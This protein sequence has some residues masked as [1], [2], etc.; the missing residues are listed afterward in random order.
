MK[1]KGNLSPLI[2]NKRNFEQAWYGFS[3]G[4]GRRDSIRKFEE[5]L[6]E[7]L[8][9]LLEAYANGTWRTS[10]YRNEEIQERKKRIISKYPIEE[11][12]IQWAAGIF[13]EPLLCDTFIRR[14]CSCVAGRGT[15]DFVDLLRKDMSLHYEDTYY[16]VQL[17]AH[18]YFQHIRSDLMKASLRRKIKDAKLLRFLDEFI[19]SY[20][21][22]LPLGLKISQILANY[23]LAAFDRDVIRIFGIADDPDKMAYWRARYV[24]DCFVTCRTRQQADELAKGV[25]YLN[26]KFDGYVKEGM[27]HY[28]RFADNIIIQHRDKAF[29]HLVTEMAIMV[30]AR[31]YYIDVNKE[32]NVRPVHAGGIDVCGYVSFHDH[33]LLRKRNKVNLCK[34][35]AKYRKRGLSPEEIRRKC[36]SRIGFATH[37]NSNNLLRKLDINMEK[38]LGTVIKNKKYNIPFKGMRFDQKKPFSDLICKTEQ[39]EDSHKIM[40]MDY[41]V[42]DSKVEKES[43]IMEVPDTASGGTKMERVERPKKCLVIRYKRIVRTIVSPTIDGG[44]DETYIFE[45]ETDKNGNPTSKDAEY[46]SY[47]GST[48]LLEQAEN[49]FDKEDLPCITV[50]MEFTNKLNKKFYKFT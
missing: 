3:D 17:D 38:R 8:D 35:V 10:D 37:A 34:E 29:L 11:H 7:N 32:W 21:Q 33:R 49:D 13:V 16:F 39:D 5:H 41:T 40:L 28:S 24:T 1:R 46:Y 6:S 15:H 31:D 26:A 2:E 9:R 36:A 47:T 18:H 50:I 43:V 25:A 14:S 44:E 30:L 27:R 22:G 42:E 12:V 19:D 45:K 48:V 23:F 4:K 20:K